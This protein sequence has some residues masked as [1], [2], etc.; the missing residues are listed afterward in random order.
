MAYYAKEADQWAYADYGGYEEVPVEHQLEEQLVEALDHHVEGS[1]N[2]ALIKALQPYAEPLKN[3]GMRQMQAALGTTPRHS[4][5]ESLAQV[6]SV[7]DHGFYGEPVQ[8][9]KVVPVT[10]DTDDSSPPSPGHL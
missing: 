3:Y 7:L 2:R 10:R 1:V 5:A 6:A 4:S 9:K 8:G